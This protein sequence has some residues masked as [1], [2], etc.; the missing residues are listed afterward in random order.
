[1]KYLVLFTFIACTF[2]LS[3]PIEIHASSEP[4]TQS[5]VLTVNVNTASSSD[6]QKLPGIGAVTAQNIIDFR[7]ENGDFSA[8]EDLL[9]VKGVGPKTLEGIR[10]QIEVK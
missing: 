2:F 9:K 1:M 5:A 7:S 6:L 3:A 4:V 8:P 10:A